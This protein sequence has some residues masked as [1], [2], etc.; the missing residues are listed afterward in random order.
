MKK[1]YVSIYFCVCIGEQCSIRHQGIGKHHD[2]LTLNNS[3]RWFLSCSTV[4][5]INSSPWDKMAA[6][7][8]M[9]FSYAFSWIKSFVFWLG[10]RWSLLLRVQLTKSRFTD[11]YV[12]LGGDVLSKQ[13]AKEVRKP[14]ASFQLVGSFSQNDNALLNMAAAEITPLLN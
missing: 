3:V 7:S 13:C 1:W 5:A 12:A 2:A 9:I 4:T 10:F 6:I 8:Q 11:I 14:L